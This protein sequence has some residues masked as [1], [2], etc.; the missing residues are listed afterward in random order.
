MAQTVFKDSHHRM[1]YIDRCN[2]SLVN[3]KLDHVWQIPANRA[4]IFAVWVREVR[5]STFRMQL[6]PRKYRLYS[7][8]GYM[9]RQLQKFP[10]N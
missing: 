9:Y 8:V 6:T 10:D 1:L 2:Q 7:Y 5:R 4:Y 3:D